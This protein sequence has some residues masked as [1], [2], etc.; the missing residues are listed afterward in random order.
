MPIEFTISR[1]IRAD[2]NFVFDWWTDLRPEDAKLVKPLK[3]REIISKTRDKIVLHDTEQM[4]FKR[5]EFD[6]IVTLRRPGSWT[7]EYNGNSAQARSEYRLEHGPKG[8]TILNYSTAIR[9]N[10]SIIRFFSPIVKPFIKRI[11][12]SEMDIFIATLERD[13]AGL[14]RVDTRKT[15]GAD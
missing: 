7:S 1:K 6:V 15:K 9:P 10:G 8:S 3:A 4:Y 5:M 13:C 2:Q 12:V 11:F 14:A